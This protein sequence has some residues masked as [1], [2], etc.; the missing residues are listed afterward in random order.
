MLFFEVYNNKVLLTY[1]YTYILEPPSKPVFVSKTFETITIRWKLHHL[2]GI[3]YNVQMQMNTQSRWMDAKCGAQSLVPNQCFLKGPVARVT[4]LKRNT[5]YHFRLYAVFKGVSSDYSLPSDSIRTAGDVESI[6]F[7]FLGGSFCYCYY[8]LFVY[9][10]A[11]LFCV[12]CFCFSPVERKIFNLGVG[13]GC[14]RRKFCSLCY[15]IC[16]LIRAFF[17]IILL[18]QVYNRVP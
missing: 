13:M 11:C 16:A 18:R 9:L 15:R 1:C 4:D 3:T 10:F 14:K 17:R 5:M 12:F 2:Q 6:V 7:F 8:C